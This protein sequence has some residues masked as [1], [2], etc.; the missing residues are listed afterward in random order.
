MF[1]CLIF[2]FLKYQAFLRNKYLYKLFLVVSIYRKI[3]SIDFNL[4]AKL[5]KSQIFPK[6]YFN[7]IEIRAPVKNKVPI[8]T[9]SSLCLPTLRA[10]ISTSREAVTRGIRK[11][12]IIFNNYSLKWR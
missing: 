4:S 11:I 12:K 9:P 8:F 10:L 6:I 5:E 1:F 3:T 7:R 2:S